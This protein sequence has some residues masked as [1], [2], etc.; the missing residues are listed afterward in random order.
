MDDEE[1]LDFLK[2]QKANACSRRD[3]LEKESIYDTSDI[4]EE[5]AFWNKKIAECERGRE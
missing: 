3:E 2:E 1:Y 4:E 5:I